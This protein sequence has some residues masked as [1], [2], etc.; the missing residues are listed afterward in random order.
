MVILAKTEN[1]RGRGE[2]KTKRRS[3]G[4]FK[5][6]RMADKGDFIWTHYVKMFS[7]KGP[8][9]PSKTQPISSHRLLSLGSHSDIT[10]IE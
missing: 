3:S 1:L 8:L 4:R 5:G 10:K 9:C 7:G 2:R 6:V